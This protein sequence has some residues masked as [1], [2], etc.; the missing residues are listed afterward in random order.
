MLNAVT[1]DQITELAADIA[2]RDA[3]VVVVGKAKVDDLSK[4]VEKGHGWGTH[5][6]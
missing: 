1:I 3:S 4:I 2:S 5:S 6:S